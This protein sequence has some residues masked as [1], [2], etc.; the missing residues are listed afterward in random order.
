MKD[1]SLKP[2]PR[3]VK[4]NRSVFTPGGEERAVRAEFKAVDVARLAG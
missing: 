1:Q 3:V 4:A 2:R